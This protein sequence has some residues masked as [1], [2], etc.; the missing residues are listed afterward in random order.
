MPGECSCHFQK[1]ND[2]RQGDRRLFGSQP[3]DRF[4]SGVERRQTYGRRASD[5]QRPQV[6]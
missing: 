2:R 1:H 5:K 4:F 3:D 6:S